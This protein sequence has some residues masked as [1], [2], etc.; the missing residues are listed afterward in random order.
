MVNQDGSVG[1]YTKKRIYLYF[2]LMILLSFLT[3][4]AIFSKGDQLG[5]IIKNLQWW[6][7]IPVLLLMATIL[8]SGSLVLYIFGKVF[9]KDYTFFQAFKLNL[10]GLFF[11]GVTPLA[12]GGQVVQLFV[13]KKQGIDKRNGLTILLFK[14]IIS[15]TALVLISTTLFVSRAQYY[16]TII[17]MK[18]MFSLGLIGFI[19][20]AVVLIG[21]YLTSYSSLVQRSMGNFIA[22]TH[23]IRK[24]DKEV[25][26]EKLE[27]F[28]QTRIDFKNGMKLLR[29]HKLALLS[30]TALVTISLIAN[31]SISYWGALAS[32]IEL[33]SENFFDSTV[34]TMFVRAINSFNPIPGAAMGTEWTHRITFENYFANGLGVPQV[35]ALSAA[36]STMLIWRTATF[37]FPVLLGFVTYFTSKDGLR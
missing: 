13:L 15:Q 10:I 27:K 17:D 29:S 9:K 7:I 21:L 6:Y 30:A 5:E 8:I 22:W 14:F 3:Y 23:R 18:M 2:G 24:M 11:N 19:S 36:N 1:K 12:S 37:T 35:M 34:L 28:T 26:A 32:G 20:N 16:S 31:G 4:L 33:T 25:S